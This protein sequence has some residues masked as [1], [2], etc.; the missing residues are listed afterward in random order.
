MKSGT[1][2]FIHGMY[3]N[4]LCWEHWLEFFQ[5]KGYRCVAPSWPASACATGAGGRDKPVEELRKSHPDP[6]LGRLTLSRVIEH[7][8]SLV[9][10]MDE[11]P[12]LIGHSMGGLVVQLLLQKGLA[13]AGVAIA[14]APPL[15]VITPKWSFIRSNWPHITPFR[16]QSQPVRMSLRR[17]QYTFT[18][19][20]PLA[21]QQAAYE[22][23][24]LPER[25]RVASGVMTKAAAIDFSQPHPPLLQVAGSNDHLIPASLNKS[26]WNRYKATPS[27]TDFKEFARRT[28]FVIGQENWQ[29][30]AEYIAAWLEKQA[31]D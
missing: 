25:R 13:T 30:V 5:S 23:Y 12:F 15:G 19:G 16:S 1:I 26:N 7:Y 3:M 9:R 21:V 2:V 6:Q 22:R 17:F 8:D 4:S 11:K 31:S 29:E 10:S 27:I 20:L 28:H 14:S 24:A 18:N